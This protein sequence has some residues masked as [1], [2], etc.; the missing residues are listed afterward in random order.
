MFLLLGLAL[1]V[2]GIDG[3]LA[4]RFQVAEVLPRW[5]GDVLDLVVDFTTYVIVP[6]YAIATG[7]SDARSGRARWRARSL[8]SP[9]RSISPTAK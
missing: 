7:G 4:R 6:A 5:S 3:P 9:A 8:P 1:V 2:D